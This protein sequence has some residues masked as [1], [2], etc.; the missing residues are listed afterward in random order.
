MHSLAMR[1][2]LVHYTAPPTIGGVERVLGEQAEALRRRGHTAELI[3]GK[4]ASVLPRLHGFDAVIVHNLFTMHFDLEMTSGLIDL[5]AQQQNVRWINWVH[6]V[7]A[8]NP[9]YAALPWT[10]PEF[11]QLRRAPENCTH[12]AVSEVRQL[13]Y[14]AVTHLP[15]TRIHIVPNGVDVQRILGLTDRISST[16]RQLSLW[17][18]DFVIVHP[19]RLVRR[20]NIELGLRVIAALTQDHA[21]SCSYLITGA[22]DPHNRDSRAYGTELAALTDELGITENVHFLGNE[23]TLTDDDVRSLYAVSDALLFPS[24]SE[25]FGLPIVEAALHGLPVF[26]S[27]IPAHRE[28]GQSIARFFD[29]DEDPALIAHDISSHPGVEARYLRR[30]TLAAW[31][32]WDGVV[33]K[34]ILP[35]LQ[36]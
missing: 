7:A 10:E 14:A 35:L 27:D 33:E 28:V 19:T 1:I 5:A 25:G 34:H 32:D 31:L 11:L 17:E 18:K 6:D 36:P 8:V 30:S 2:A 29:L 24:T 16:V 22:A 4:A 20:K 15:A 26:C 21:L 23:G 9:H 12:V 3:C 13:Q